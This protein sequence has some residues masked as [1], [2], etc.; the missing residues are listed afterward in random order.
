V[1][2]TNNKFVVAVDDVKGTVELPFGNTYTL[3]SFKAELEKRINQLA[4]DTG[5]TVSGVKVGFD[6]VKNSFTFT[7]GTASTDSYIKV[8]GDARWGLDGLD[9]KFG[10]TTTWIKPKPFTDV[11]EVSVSALLEHVSVSKIK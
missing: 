10:T 2:A 11:T 5:S 6:R 8:T 1:D 9:A 3:D 4:N 7:T